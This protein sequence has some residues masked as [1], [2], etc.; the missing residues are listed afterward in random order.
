MSKFHVN[1]KGE[2]GRCSAEK[3]HCPYGDA[4]HHYA[5]K[6]EAQQAYEA[7]MTPVPVAL[8]KAQRLRSAHLDQ[9]VAHVG[10]SGRG[11]GRGTVDDPINVKG[12]TLLAARL[13]S[14]GKHVRLN[15]R[16][17]VGTLLKDLRAIVKECEARGETAPTFDLCKVSVPKTNLFCASTIGVPR[18]HMPQLT[19]FAEPGSPGDA[20]PKRAN[21][22]VDI[23]THFKADLRELGVR[24]EQRTVDAS[25]LKASQAELD[26]PK[27]ARKLAKAR[28]GK[29]EP[30][31]IFVTRDGYI[32][33]GHHFF[34]TKISLEM[35]TG[36]K[37]KVT[38][39]MVD[40]EI[41]E[42]IAVANAYA[43]HMGIQTKTLGT[44]A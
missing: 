1:S 43:K 24:I 2:P 35:D 3:G 10:N 8:T 39:E 26:G 13:L 19:G 29:L 40:L 6:A 33:D 11:N 28:A 21:G 7:S 36:V 41:G 4:E 30:K 27:V 20:L 18:V 15:K 5:T 25:F 44:T 32:I 14:E 38:V 22:K 9:L 42:A 23:S 12:D 31:V 16:A 17:E 34:A 37:Q